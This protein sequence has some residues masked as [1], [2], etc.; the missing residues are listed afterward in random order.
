VQA[1]VDTAGR[2]PEISVKLWEAIRGPVDDGRIHFPEAAKIISDAGIDVRGLCGGDRPL[3]NN[4]DAILVDVIN[5]DRENGTNGYPAL[6]KLG[7]ILASSKAE[8]GNNLKMAV[9]G[10]NEARTGE[11]KRQLAA[12]I[13]KTYMNLQ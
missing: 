3:M 8:G 6:K 4:V 10:L 1:R 7:A 9:R 5:L 12:L 11:D 13:E 2:P